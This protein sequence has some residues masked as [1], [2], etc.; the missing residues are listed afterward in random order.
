MEKSEFIE[1]YVTEIMRYTR[2]ERR[3]AIDIAETSFE[4]WDG[5]DTPEEGVHEELSYWGD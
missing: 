1:R 4:D 2:M 5:V 3:V